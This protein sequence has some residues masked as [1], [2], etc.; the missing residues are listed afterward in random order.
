MRK[1]DIFTMGKKVHLPAPHLFCRPS[2][3]RLAG[4][5]IDENFKVWGRVKRAKTELVAH[6]WRA[7]CEEKKNQVLS[8]LDE[9]Y[10]FK[11]LKYHQKSYV[12]YILTTYIG[13]LGSFGVATCDHVWPYT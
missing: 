10:K 11:I 5:G 4:R 7:N 9:G 3:R 12:P 13:Y 1:L 8:F 6:A 2:N